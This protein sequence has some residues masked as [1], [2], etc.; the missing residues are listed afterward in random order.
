MKKEQFLQTLRQHLAHLP[1]N[2]I[3]DIVRDQEEF[4]QDAMS[5]GRTEEQAVAS[6]G[7]PKA[8]ASSLSAETK[9]KKAEQSSNLSQQV[10]QTFGAVFAIL[11]L[12][13]L[14]IIFVLGPFLFLSAMVF[15]GWAISF[16]T[17][18]AAW[19]FLLGFFF[20]LAFVS[21]GFWVHAS[22]FFFVVGWI[23][24]SL[25]MFASM[26]IVTRAFA[27]GVLAYLKWNINFISA[28]TPQAADGQR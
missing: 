21:V 20:K 24:V 8:F 26:Y 7:D 6:L 28:R 4:I 1:L 27:M 3:N 16:G 22:S 23:G 13:P 12:A 19:A 17:F 18:I 5:A 15:A 2:E 14:N 25:L 9:I 10:R 11:A